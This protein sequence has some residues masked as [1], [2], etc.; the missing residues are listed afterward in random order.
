MKSFP[1]GDTSA[2][3]LGFEIRENELSPSLA[4]LCAGLV[5]RDIACELE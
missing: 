2:R 1:Q 5:K 3:Q 4:V